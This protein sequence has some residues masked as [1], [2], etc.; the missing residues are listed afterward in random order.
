MP[1]QSVAASPSAGAS[2]SA[3]LLQEQLD[4][5]SKNTEAAVFR[6]AEAESRITGLSAELQAAQRA[7]QAGLCMPCPAVEPT[8]CLSLIQRCLL[9]IVSWGNFLSDEASLQDIRAR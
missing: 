9:R 6:A 1:R 3:A 7:E 8:A 5:A 2:G 4:R